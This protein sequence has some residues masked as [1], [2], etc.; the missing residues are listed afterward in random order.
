MHSLEVHNVVMFC[1]KGH[2]CMYNT[3]RYNEGGPCVPPM[4]NRFSQSPWLIG[5]SSYVGQLSA[6]KNLS[7]SLI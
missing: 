4:A 2:P 5:L 3:G 7:G 1:M 6:V